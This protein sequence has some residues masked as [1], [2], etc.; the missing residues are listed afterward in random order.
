MLN[1]YNEKIEFNKM[2]ENK[3]YKFHSTVTSYTA[4]TEPVLIDN[5]VKTKKYT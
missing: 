4:Y 5:K 1:K 2:T 3:C